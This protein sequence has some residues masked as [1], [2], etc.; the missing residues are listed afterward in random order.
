M[1]IG[2]TALLALAD[3]L[4]AQYAELV[5]IPSDTHA[6]NLATGAAN[7]VARVQAYTDADLQVA[8]LAAV[9]TEQKD[10]L[11]PYTS[12]AALFGATVRALNGTAVT[13]GLDAYLTTNAI[14][15]GPNF[16]TLYQLVMGRALTAANIDAGRT[17]T[18]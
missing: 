1:T 6:T 7:N 9:N 13:G 10:S 12:P 16:A 18:L 14:Q 4:G 2:T 15:V 11:T 5:A 3:S 8:L 17:E